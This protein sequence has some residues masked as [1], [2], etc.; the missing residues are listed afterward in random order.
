MTAAHARIRYA[1]ASDQFD[2]EI[3]K[4]FRA[5]D[6]GLGKH[7]EMPSQTMIFWNEI[8]EKMLAAGWAKIV[9]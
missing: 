6:L 1:I 9:R 2:R 8:M 5:V 4:L 7:I 3:E